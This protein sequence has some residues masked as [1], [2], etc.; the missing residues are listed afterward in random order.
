MQK[1]E[2]IELIITC[3]L[4][5]ILAFFVVNGLKRVK[6]NKLSLKD[7]KVFIKEQDNDTGKQK[8]A[9]NK[10]LFLELEE[11]AG[12]LEVKRDPFATAVILPVKVYPHGLHLKGIAWDEK[13]PTVII[14][15]NI[16]GEGDKIG[17]N[18]IVRIEPER[19]IL[20]D[21]IADFY[22]KIELE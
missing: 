13:M 14:N 10:D 7:K 6:K 3:G 19:V 4:I 22:L 16:A 1:K 18:T 2:K 12:K 8:N 20:N 21:G 9:T 11:E 5:L 15:D 17:D